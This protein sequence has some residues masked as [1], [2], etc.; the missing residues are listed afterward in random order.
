MDFLEIM[1][2]NETEKNLATQKE[3]ID[4]TIEEKKKTTEEKS[5]NPSTEES[6]EEEKKEENDED[7]EEEIYAVERICSRRFFEGKVQYL[8]KWENYP[9]ADN[10]WEP[11]EN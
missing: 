2:S 6:K 7:D 8:V 10:T 5:N 1:L 9:E 4:K 3:S 11:I